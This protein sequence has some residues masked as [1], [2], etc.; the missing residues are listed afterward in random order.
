[1]GAP[2]DIVGPMARAPRVTPWFSADAAGLA[3][4]GSF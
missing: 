1:V 2:D 3:W 4:S